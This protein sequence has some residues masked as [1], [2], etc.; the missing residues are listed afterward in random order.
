[1]LCLTHSSERR[2]FIPKPKDSAADCNGQHANLLLSGSED[3]TARLW[4]LRTQKTAYCMVLPRLEE[5]EAVEV[6]SVAFHPSILDGRQDDDG[7]A[8]EHSNDSILNGG[9]DCTV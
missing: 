4:D 5:S 8:T 7:D 6:T 1:M 2:A 9:R 3:G